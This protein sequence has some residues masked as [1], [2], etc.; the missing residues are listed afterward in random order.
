MLKNKRLF[1]TITTNNRT[2]T[3]N[4]QGT[5]IDLL[6][7]AHRCLHCETRLY[8]EERTFCTVCKR[9]RKTTNDAV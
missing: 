4:K 1:H 6:W 3:V 2:V 9:S 7:H 8:D 5:R